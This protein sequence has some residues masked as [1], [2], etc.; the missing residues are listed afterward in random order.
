MATD[1][2]RQERLAAMFVSV[3]A[4]FIAAM[5]WLSRPAPGDFVEADPD[6]YVMFNVVIHGAMLVVLM[7]F[8][9]RVGRLTAAQ[10]GQRIPLTLL[11]L[12]GI[13]AAAY[14]VGRDLGLV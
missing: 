5:E 2:V 14:V 7:I 8:L 9:A 4:L 11:I 10:P 3:G 6:W 13:A 1:T 12:V